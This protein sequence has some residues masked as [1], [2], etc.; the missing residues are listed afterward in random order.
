M[1]D[2]LLIFVDGSACFGGNPNPPKDYNASL[3][4]GLYPEVHGKPLNEVFITLGEGTIGEAEWLALVAG[5]NLARD[6]GYKRLRLLS[7]HFQ[8]VQIVNRRELIRSSKIPGV[9]ESLRGIHS[10]IDKE[11]DCCYVDWIPRKQNK[12]HNVIVRGKVNL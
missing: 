3:Y 6:L 10:F 12:A 4:A 5:L 7:D 8:I 2:A 1:D 9:N 11:F